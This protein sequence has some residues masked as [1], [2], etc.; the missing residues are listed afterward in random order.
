MI[1]LGYEIHSANDL[2]EWS[3]FVNKGAR[4]FKIDPHYRRDEGVIVLTHNEPTLPS[5]A[6]YK[7]HDLLYCLVKD[8]IK[9]II[10]SEGQFQISL[11]FKNAPSISE[12]CAEGVQPVHVTHWLQTI[13]DF[14]RQSQQLSL[15]ENMK[16]TFI[17]DGGGVPVDCLA[18]RWRPWLSVWMN[19]TTCPANAFIG[20]DVNQGYDRFQILNDR[21]IPIIW[22][23]LAEAHY[24]KFVEGD[25]PM[26]AWEQGSQERIGSL[27]ETFESG[28][29]FPPGLAIAINIDP[30]Q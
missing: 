4:S 16:I 6:Y 14:F 9:S 2:R 29:S 17:L 1:H 7:L 21:G 8:P 11:C 24:G 3:A 13:D 12:I 18:Q 28:P 27:I 22:H 30:C 23:R 25:Y 15:K 5:S 19:Y 26:V 10:Q 20:N